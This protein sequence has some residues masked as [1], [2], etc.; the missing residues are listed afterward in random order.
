[1]NDENHCTSSLKFPIDEVRSTAKIIRRQEIT[2]ETFVGAIVVKHFIQASIAINSSFIL[3]L[4]RPRRCDSLQINSARRGRKEVQKLMKAGA[5]LGMVKSFGK[6]VLH[7][8][9]NQKR[10]DRNDG[11][12]EEMVSANCDHHIRGFP[13]YYKSRG[14]GL[15]GI[16]Q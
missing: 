10:R 9:L 14:P 6:K 1:M 3:F 4:Y 2:R 11:R 13:L 8:N 5:D 7:I 15:G 12:M 16:K